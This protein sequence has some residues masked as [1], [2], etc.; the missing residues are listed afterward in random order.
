MKPVSVLVVIV[1]YRTGALAME[2]VA[3]LAGE[4]TARG[5]T[6][7]VVVDNGSGDDSADLIARGIAERGFGDWCTLDAIAR[8]GGFAAGNNEGLRW[9]REA[10][11]GALPDY[12]WLLNPDTYA[13]AGAIGGLVDFL[14]AH[15]AAGI[16]G[17]RCLWE[18][19]G[20]RHSAFRFHS[21]MGEL[22]RAINFGPVTRLL[23]GRQVA[24]P[25]IDRSTRVDWV[26]GSSF[27]I[28][29]AVIEAIGP[30]DEGFF[31]YLEE[32]DYCSRAAAA[33]FEV[34]FAPDSVIT[35]I[36][37]QSTG[38]TGQGR[39]TTRRPRYWFEARARFFIKRYGVARAH[40]ANLAW[41]AAY[42]IGRLIGA[43]RGKANDD[44]PRLWADFVAAYYGPG[45]FMYRAGKIAA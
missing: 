2:A 37:G 19:G 27:M 12:V 38:V 26:S 31:L 32:A 22:I 30:M 15:P 36:G 21:P 6:H 17:G 16:A 14:R 40:L 29:R 20:V 35:H 34:W 39:R 41:I 3:S 43:L 42:P 11:G 24:L 25:R 8:N 18:D 13:Q 9:Y 45:G 33:G 7:V 10:C 5:D 1:N 23:G 28:R 4:V 44:P